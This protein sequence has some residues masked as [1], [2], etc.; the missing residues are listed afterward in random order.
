M[1]RISKLLRF[2]VEQA[3]QA[4]KYHNFRESEPDN[5]AVQLM[6]VH[7]SK[8]LEFHT[9]FVPRLNKRDF[10]VSKM[11]GRQYYHILGG[12]F[13]E[14]KE[15]YESDIE[16]ERKLFYVAITRAKHNLFLSYTLDKQPI[17]EFVS[18]A[19]ESAYLDVDRAELAEYTEKVIDW[20]LVR[21]A[22]EA[23]YDHYCDASH[24]CKGIMGEY[25]D[26]CR[27]GPEAIIAEAQQLG[28]I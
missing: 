6:T 1:Y 20:D 27:Q 25:S 11:G 16:D 10:P 21:E 3:N 4:Y 28:L 8:G 14:N 12:T 7:K 23:L 24:F 2:L 13:E 15:K 19:A 18:N 26:I 17:S 22:R 9:V 5:D